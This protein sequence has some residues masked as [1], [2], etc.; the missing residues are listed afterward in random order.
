MDKRTKLDKTLLSH[1]G[2]N[3]LP[4]KGK[5]VFCPSRVKPDGSGFRSVRTG[6]TLLESF[7]S[8]PEFP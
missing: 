1:P 6:K 7:L 2:Q 5:G 4:Y 3:P 8:P